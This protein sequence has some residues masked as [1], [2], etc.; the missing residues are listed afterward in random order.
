MEILLAEDERSIALTLR[1]DLEEAGHSVQWEGTGLGA[2]RALQE[3]VFD[4]L[5]T[6]VR[7]PGKSGMELLA[8]AKARRPETEVLVITGFA[9][10]EQ[11]VEAMRMGAFDY[12]Q[13]PF[14]NEVVLERVAQ[15]QK[16]R[17]LEDENL[18]LKRALTGE[19]DPFEGIVGQSRRMQDLFK[20]VETVAGSDANVLILGESGTGKERFARAIHRLS[21][22]AGAPFVAISC[23]ALPETL[24]E[25]ELF[26]HERGAFTGASRARKGR[27]ELADGGTVFLDDIDDMSLPTPQVEAPAR[28]AGARVRRI[29]SER[30]VAVDIRVIAATRSPTRPARPRG[31][32]AEDLYYRLNVV[33]VEAPAAARA[34]EDIP[35]LAAHFIRRYGRGRD[36]EVRPEDLAAMEAYSWPGNI[37][38]SRTT[39]S[40]IAWP[41]PSRCS[42]ARAPRAPGLGAEPGHRRGGPGDAAPARGARRGRAGPPQAR[43]GLGRRPPD[44]RRQGARHQPQGAVGEAQGLRDRVGGAAR[45]LAL[46]SVLLTGPQ[47]CRDP[48]AGA[49]GQGRPSASVGDAAGT[50]PVRQD[51]DAGARADGTP[52]APRWGQGFQ[53]F[54]WRN[55]GPPLS[56]DLAA[57]LRGLGATGVCVDQDEDPVLCA[58]LGI[59][60]YLDHAAGKGIL[61]LREPD[62]DRA[63]LAYE[64]D[65]DRKSLARPRPLLAPAT[66]HELLGLLGARVPRAADHGAAFVSLDDEISVT[67]LANPLDFCFDPTTLAAFRGWLEARYGTVDALAAVWGRRFPTFAEVV[68]PTTDEVRGRELGAG[69]MPET[70]GDWN[71]FRAFMDRCLA[72]TVEALCRR[73]RELAPGLPVGFEGGQAPSAFGGWDW[74]LLLESV[75]YVEPYDIGGTREL[76]RSY[77][78][79][80]T[81][82]YETVFPEQD[83]AMADRVRARLWDAYAH[84]LDGVILWSSGLVFDGGDPKALSAYGQALRRE[85]PVLTSDQAAALQHARAEPARIAI[86][87]EQ[88][89]VRLHWMLDSSRDGPTWTRR[90]GSH[91]RTH[92]TSQADRLSW[93]RLLQDLGHP[94]RFVPSADLPG[95]YA[96]GVRVLV[97]P[98]ALS[99]GVREAEAIVD[100][101]DAGGL[102]VADER[103]GRYDDHL[104]RRDQALLDR[105]F[106]VGATALSRRQVFE[107]RARPGGPTLASGLALAETGLRSLFQTRTELRDG[108]ALWFER[109]RGKGMAVLMNLVVATYASD[110]LLVDRSTACRDLRGRLLR[111]LRRRGLTP[112]VAVEVPGYPTVVEKLWR[113][114][115]D[116]DGLC[117]VRA[118]CLE[119]D[120]LFLELAGKGPQPMV[121]HLPFAAE[122]TDA[123]RGTLV[124]RG[125]RVSAALDPVRGTFL[126]VRRL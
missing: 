49:A 109:E 42:S 4:V 126:R 55:G 39:S 33:P 77:L 107:G 20:L 70:L 98:S 24:L 17:E 7:L 54:L 51:G 69:L 115:P 89:N 124:G 31:G 94:F 119:S 68:P 62:F 72:D 86:L 25:D 121:L 123:L 30:T 67:R 48:G 63:R 78:R 117:V 14:L 21:P 9:T 96:R 122:V 120:V 26:G 76:V 11:A 108:E 1:E 88:R 2:E 46:A 34:P 80:G 125:R 84:G 16:L 38:S 74:R 83:P 105:L 118:N 101:V 99:V 50:R 81:L 40:A 114:L 12:F 58:T 35:L 110:R 3:K 45:C 36:Y 41:D 73:S 32:S 22:R 75:D 97:L 64:A 28:A 93:I 100:F 113:L 8:L 71:D 92:S 43:A 10:V 65:R 59:P 79:P 56:R 53:A 82:H 95:L 5:V 37:R 6:D 23:G 47:A 104:N 85:L 13:K 61:H 57:A 87:E 102:V 111:L 27:F 44:Q 106:G 18:R 60:F 66:R 103:P 15:I 52:V 91:E 112:P 29:G 19:G 116:G 90:F